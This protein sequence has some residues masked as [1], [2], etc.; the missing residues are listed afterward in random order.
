MTTDEIFL[1]AFCD[2]CNVLYTS[3]KAIKINNPN[4]NCDKTLMVIKL[5]WWQNSKCDK[6]KMWPNSKTQI[7]TKQKKLNCDKT[8]KL[9]VWQNISYDTSQFMT[10]DILEW[11]VSKN[12]LTPW[13]PM[14]FSLGSFLR[15]SRCFHTCPFKLS[16]S[17]IQI[18]CNFFHHKSV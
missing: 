9:K 14:R 15:F 13:Q 8:Q 7:V 18:F 4:M 6:L 12:I 10:K 11:S 2:S 3:I 1:A 17:T 5:K 16:K